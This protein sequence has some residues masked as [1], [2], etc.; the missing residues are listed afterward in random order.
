MR[1]KTWTALVL[2]AALSALAGC[3][4]APAETDAA[5]SAPSDFAPA[6]ASGGTEA[7]APE[8][9]APED[10]FSFAEMKNWEFAFSSGAGAWGTTLCV[11]GDGSFSGEYSDSDLDVQYRCDFTGQFTQPVQV[12][13]YVYAVEIAQI[14]YQHPAGTEEDRDGVHYIYSEPYGLDGAERI[15]IYL[16]GAPLSGLPEEFVNWVTSALLAMEGVS[17]L[18]QMTQL[19]CYGLYN[20]EQGLGFSSYDAA[21]GV[22][23]SLDWAKTRTA[24]LEQAIAGDGLAQGEINSAYDEMYHIWDSVL[25]QAWNVLMRILPQDEAAGL[26]QE[27]M[28]WIAWKEEE[29]AKAGEEYGGSLTLMAQSQRAAELT[30]DRVRALTA[31]LE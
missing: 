7:A 24:E 30:R 29:I 4:P 18:S 27:E 3:A 9:A 21:A 19:P 10:A 20:E 5:A 1:R 31:Y 17:D 25:N 14:Q 13:E 2:A 22:W 28:D 15:L 6:D 12:D 16:P 8:T 23:T 26:I 11:H